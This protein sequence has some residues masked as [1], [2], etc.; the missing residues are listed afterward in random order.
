MWSST[1]FTKKGEASMKARYAVASMVVAVFLLV[2]SG[3]I[4]AADTDKQ[5]GETMGEKLDDSA[6]TSKVKMELLKNKETSAIKTKVKTE[7]G[8]VTLT[9]KAKNGAEK[10]LVTKIASGV[11]GVKKINNN[12]VV[13]EESK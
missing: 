4:Y 5:P 6:I 12:M 2:Q 7:N 1:F 9:G 10:E 11:K 13:Q 8:V 3:A